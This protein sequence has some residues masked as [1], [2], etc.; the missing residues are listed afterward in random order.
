MTVR[1]I[2]ACLETNAT[3]YFLRRNWH[4]YLGSSSDPL[5]FLFLSRDYLIRE[6]FCMCDGPRLLRSRWNIIRCWSSNRDNWSLR[7]RSNPSLI[8]FPCWVRGAATG[9]PG[10]MQEMC[11]YVR[12]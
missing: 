1:A 12:F 3:G 6:R 9:G 10:D 11:A 4:G 5:R 7:P 8:T 2:L